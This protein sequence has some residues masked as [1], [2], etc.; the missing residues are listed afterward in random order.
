MLNKLFDSLLYSDD[1][2]IK[3][4]ISK[5]REILKEENIFISQNYKDQLNKIIKK[6]K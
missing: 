2:L 1:E 6:N 3:M 5:V 4:P